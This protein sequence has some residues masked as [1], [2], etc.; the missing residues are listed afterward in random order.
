MNW[1][2]A[3]EMLHIKNTL[4]WLHPLYQYLSTSFGNFSV[5]LNNY[6]L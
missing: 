5:M 3:L 6:L 1:Y 2:G 4:L